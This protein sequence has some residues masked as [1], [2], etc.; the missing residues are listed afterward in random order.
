MNKL[1]NT[2]RPTILQDM[3][4][5]DIDD[6][7]AEA[8]RVMFLDSGILKDKEG[9]RKKALMFKGNNCELSFYVFSKEN[10]FRRLLYSM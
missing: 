3:I 9:E 1:T 4:V 10:P 8:I 5:E 7:D 6:L 2:F